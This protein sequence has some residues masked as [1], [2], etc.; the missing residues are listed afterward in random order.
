MIRDIVVWISEE[1]F[2]MMSGVPIVETWLILPW[3][4]AFVVIMLIPIMPVLSQKP[5]SNLMRAFNLAVFLAVFMVGFL[6]VIGV[7]IAQTQMVRECRPVTVDAVHPDSGEVSQLVLTECREKP[8]FYSEFG[9]WQIVPV[10]GN[11]PHN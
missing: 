6:V 4:M 3:V 7:P 5:T 8:N 1:L 10:Q 2:L 11:Y 9:S